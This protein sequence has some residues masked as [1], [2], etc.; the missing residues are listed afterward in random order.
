MANLLFWQRWLFAL[1][2]GVV[3]FGLALAFFNGSPTFDLFNRQIDP[4]FWG[5]QP[6]SSEAGLFRQWV[7]GVLGATMAGWGAMIAFIAHY[8]F[9]RKEQWAWY[10]VLIGMLI[11]Y[12]VDT[13]ISLAFGVAFNAIFNTAIFILASL[14]LMFTRAVFFPKNPA[15]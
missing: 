1:S 5:N 7:Y 6:I 10:S 8:P 3:L 2:V 13:S 15:Q 9:R 12:V 4:A 14:P 11:W